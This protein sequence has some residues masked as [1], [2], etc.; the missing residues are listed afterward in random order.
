MGKLY[1]I[2][3]IHGCYRKLCGVLGKIDPDPSTDRVIFLGDY[4]NRGKN[5][6]AVIDKLIAFRKDHPRT[7]F[8]KGNHDVLLLDYLNGKKENVFL[9]SGGLET[10]FS[11][12]IIPPGPEKL[13]NG[14]P[15][16]HRHFLF[17][18]L[19]YWEEQDYIFVHAGMEKGRHPALQRHE[20]LYWADRNKFLKQTFPE[21]HRKIIFGHFTHEKP[22][23]MADKIGIDTGAVYG[24]VLT[25][26]VLPDMRFITS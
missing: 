19:P 12:G 9:Q 2:G 16:S 26:L 10:L 1:A 23:V 15:M 20:W 13:R 14:I 3:D 5:S 21:N 25:C 6:K 7:V 18:L 24:G 8:L 22:L 4:V 11:Y 17:D